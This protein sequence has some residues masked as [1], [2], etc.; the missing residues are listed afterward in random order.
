MG[1][2]SYHR[3]PG[4]TDLE[5]L[6]SELVDQASGYELLDGTTVAN[7]FYGALRAPDKSVTALVVLQRR[8]PAGDGF[9]YTRKEVSETMGP[10]EACCPGRILDLLTPIEDCAHEGEWCVHCGAEIQ[11]RGERWLSH[12]KPHQHVEAAGPRCYSGYPVAASS[13]GERPYHA[14]GGTPPCSR[15]W[16]REWRRRCREQLERQAA[17]QPIRAGETFT[18]ASRWTFADD[19]SEDTFTLVDGRRRLYRRAGDGRQVRLPA[20]DSWPDYHVTSASGNTYVAL[21]KETS[22]GGADR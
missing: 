13:D 17:R 11:R 5:H 15:C 10:A 4:Q 22:T 1:W 14:P 9:N 12:R 6:R 8:G 19:V 20:R 18:V 7:V 21:S 2:T 3:Q 16:A